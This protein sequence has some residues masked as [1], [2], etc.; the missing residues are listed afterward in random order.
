MTAGN[1]SGGGKCASICHQHSL[2]HSLNS[3]S[4]TGGQRGGKGARLDAA[5][6]FIPTPEPVL[7]TYNAT[8]PIADGHVH[9]EA[10]AVCRQ[11]AT[12]IWC[13]NGDMVLQIRNPTGRWEAENRGLELFRWYCD[14]VQ[15]EKQARKRG[16]GGIPEGRWMHSFALKF[17]IAAQN[18]P[19]SGITLHLPLVVD[20]LSPL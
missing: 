13:R 16:S 8:A 3:W 14:G 18:P 5:A 11:T 4:I 1:P 6:R 2:T 9:A 7:S 19:K 12:Y 15:S 10:T 20:I 17:N